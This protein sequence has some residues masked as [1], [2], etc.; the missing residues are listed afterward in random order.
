[1]TLALVILG[2][3]TVT[4]GTWVCVT[5]F[6]TTTPPLG[7]AIAHLHRP[8]PSAPVVAIGGRP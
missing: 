6:T 7:R 4:A 1:M 5:A 8:R 3:L 2:G